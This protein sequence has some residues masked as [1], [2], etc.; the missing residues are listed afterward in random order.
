MYTFV[1]KKFPSPLNFIINMYF[2]V[3]W[4]YLYLRQR[5]MSHAT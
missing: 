5:V 3:T 2:F 4:V 1:R